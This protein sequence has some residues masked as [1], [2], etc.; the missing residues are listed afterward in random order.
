MNAPELTLHY[1]RLDHIRGQ[2]ARVEAMLL[3]DVEA[4]PPERE[5]AMAET[6]RRD[7]DLG[8]RERERE[9]EGRRTRIRARPA[10]QTV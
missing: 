10:G 4:Q 8:L 5:H 1:Q 7:V 2:I 9:V 3:D 6:A